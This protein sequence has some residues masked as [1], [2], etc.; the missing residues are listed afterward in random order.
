MTIYEK[1]WTVDELEQRYYEWLTGAVPYWRSR[2]SILLRHLYETPFR[3]TMLMDENRVGDGLSMRARFIWSEH[4]SADERDLLKKQRPCSVLE[5]MIGLAQRFEEEYMTQYT[6]EDPIGMWFDPM[7]R[8]L[9]L[10]NYDDQHFDL[11]GYDLIM[12]AFLNRTY[13]PDGR[14]SLFY[15]PGI[16][17]DMRQ[18][19]IWK[20]MMMWNNYK[21][22][23][24]YG[25]QNAT[26]F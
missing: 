11:Y 22:E 21:E 19:E 8:S 12:Q 5:V 25:K 7:I 18:V 26:Q 4:L 10:Q 15:I 16:E 9:G 1:G 14:G 6:G 3:V 24:T 13:F 20:Q 2:Y 17:T 23:N